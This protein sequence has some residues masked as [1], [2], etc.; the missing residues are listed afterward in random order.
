MKKSRWDLDEEDDGQTLK[1]EA[2]PRRKQLKAQKEGYD[3]KVEVVEPSKQQ[4]PTLEISLYANS[5]KIFGC[6]SVDSFKKLNRIDEGTYGIVYRAQDLATGEIVALKKLKL[7]RE[8]DGFPITS[9][10][11]IHTLT[12]AKHKH[13][14]NLREIVV[15]STMDR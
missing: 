5:P 7:E 10:R 9:L 11:E 3:K 8:R 6:R 2:G 4:S 13:V 15:G 1:K 14:V 12:L